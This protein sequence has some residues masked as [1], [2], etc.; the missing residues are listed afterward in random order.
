MN[1]RFIFA[2]AIFISLI[3][4]FYSIYGSSKL[5]G[6]SKVAVVIMGISFAFGKLIIAILLKTNW[7]EIK[8]TLRSYLIF[9]LITL[10]VWTSVGIYGFLADAYNTTKLQDDHSQVKIFLIRKKQKF[11]EE[12][13]ADLKQQLTS[14]NTSVENLR[15]SLS[16]DNQTQQVIKGQVITNIT[17]SSKK[18]VQDQLD[19]AITEKEILQTKILQNNDSIS[20]NELKAIE[21]E[22]ST[23]TAS[24]LGPLKFIS[25]VTGKDMDFIVNVFLFLIISIFDPLALALLW[26]YFSIGKSSEKQE[27]DPQ[28]DPT[29]PIPD[30][31]IDPVQEKKPRNITKKLG[32]PKKSKTEINNMIDSIINPIEEPKS[33]PKPRKK[34][35]NDL[36]KKTAKNIENAVDKK[37][38]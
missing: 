18:A 21:I 13:V 9:A 1:K 15:K 6:G 2:A 36:T 32:R 29:P 37:K 19:K 11:F 16:T 24:E 22:Q 35:S 10:S 28:V 4:E 33:K 25:K 5:F 14:V 20:R 17:S 38:V 8:S 23:N 3:A 7:D 30:P 34:L 27:D 31:I 26:S 12:N